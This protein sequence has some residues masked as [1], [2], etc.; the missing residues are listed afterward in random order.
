MMHLS[1]YMAGKNR[2]GKIWSDDEFAALIGRSRPTI[3]R[4]R[5]RKLRPD[6]DTIRIIADVTDGLVTADD[7]MGPLPDEERP[8]V[9]PEGG[10]A[11]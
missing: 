1:D 4:I 10:V 2:E 5:R 6:W 9:E 7:F 11:A 8:A 3:S